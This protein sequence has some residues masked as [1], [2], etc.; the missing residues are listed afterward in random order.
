MGMGEGAGANILCRFGL[1]FP[2][3]CVGLILIDATGSG[4]GAD[5]L[6]FCKI[7]NWKEGG[8]K[9]VEKV[10]KYLA[11]HRLDGGRKDDWKNRMCPA[12]IGRYLR[13]F[14]K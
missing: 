13:S 5:E 3:R 6:L 12:N 8:M 1:F 14:L 7:F 9:M 11:Y 2:N 4:A 10:M